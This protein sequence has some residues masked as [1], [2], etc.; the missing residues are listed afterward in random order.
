MF[1]KTLNFSD[2]R[3]WDLPNEYLRSLTEG[4]IEEA[5]RHQRDDIAECLRIAL[6]RSKSTPIKIVRCF[7]KLLSEVKK[8]VNQCRSWTIRLRKKVLY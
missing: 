2:I 1:P 4:L 5:V 6:K 3:K 7:Q 8:A